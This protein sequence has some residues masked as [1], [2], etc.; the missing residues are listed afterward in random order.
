MRADDFLN[1]VESNSNGNIDE[2]KISSSSNKNSAR[3][4]LERIRSISIT[5]CEQA[6]LDTGAE[7]N[8]VLSNK[9]T[10]E[11]IQKL[12]KVLSRFQ[13]TKDS[14]DGTYEII[15]KTQFKNK[16]NLTI[17]ERLKE[18]DETVEYTVAV[19]ENDICLYRKA[20]KILEAPIENFEEFKVLMLGAF[21]VMPEDEAKKIRSA[22]RINR[23]VSFAF[24]DYSGACDFM[25]MPLRGKPAVSD[26][27]KSFAHV[28]TME[29]AYRSLSK[30][31]S[32]LRL[33]NIG[34][35]RGIAKE[36]FS[37]KGFKELAFMSTSL[38][39]NV[40]YE[41]SGG[42]RSYDG[43][44]IMF[45]N[46]RCDKILDLREVACIDNGGAKTN[47]IK[48]YEVLIKSN[49]EVT[50]LKKVAT[51]KGRDV[52]TADII[53]CYEDKFTAKIKNIAKMFYRTAIGNATVELLHYIFTEKQFKSYTYKIVGLLEWYVDITTQS[54]K[55]I[56]I[57]VV[58]SDEQDIPEDE[59]EV[60]VINQD[61]SKEE[62]DEFD[63]D[64]VDEWFDKKGK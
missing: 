43:V 54:D 18:E 61:G 62:F 5:A 37:E 16:I 48:E 23:S 8:K 2:Q 52:Y 30:D 33:E 24:E 57:N 59:I 32:K 50:N 45:N 3:E 35:F 21:N 47:D 56:I 4:I 20:E 26:T 46:I 44:I 19:E 36:R 39:L 22:A 7:T 1:E 63:R 42:N 6:K 12:E 9:K 49:T 13:I 53:D 17:I 10:F 11:I 15:D 41:F 14:I 60:T 64:I 55:E 28:I 25:Q 27:C 58:A 51:Y 38:S 31:Y 34:I 29:M 40:A